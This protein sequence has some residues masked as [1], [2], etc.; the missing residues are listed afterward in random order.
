MPVRTRA[1]RSASKSYPTIER[2]RETA[3]GGSL[4][5]AND[6]G[7]GLSSSP[8][9]LGGRNALRGAVAGA[10]KPAMHDE[11]HATAKGQRSK[12]TNRRG[13]TGQA[14]A[15]GEVY[16]DGHEHRNAARPHPD[17][18]C[19]LRSP[20][21]PRFWVNINF[22]RRWR[23]AHRAHPLEDDFQNQL[24]PSSMVRSIL[25]LGSQAINRT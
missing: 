24:Q 13:H 12:Q 14:S 15:G 9:R 10:A 16:A 4:A 18:T 8:G 20:L 7:H 11:V 21:I 5:G 2:D 19:G 22:I 17:I 25:T 6:A 1:V 3:P 23:A